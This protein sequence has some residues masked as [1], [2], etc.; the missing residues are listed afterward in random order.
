M[1]R[2]DLRRSTGEKVEKVLQLAANDCLLVCI[3]PSGRVTKPK[4]FQLKEDKC[5]HVYL[6][7]LMYVDMINDL[8]WAAARARE[9]K[10]QN[11][12]GT[13]YGHI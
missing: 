5:I 4:C 8:E 1:N 10:E 6:R 9:R 12:Y 2:F 3:G 13:N 11:E 7:R